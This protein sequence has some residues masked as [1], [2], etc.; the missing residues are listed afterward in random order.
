MLHPRTFLPCPDC[1]EFHEVAVDDLEQ[2]SDWG[3]CP[4]SECPSNSQI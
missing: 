1:D 3:A 4:N 2:H